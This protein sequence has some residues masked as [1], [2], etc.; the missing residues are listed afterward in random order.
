[1]PIIVEVLTC[2]RETTNIED[3]YAIAVN[4]TEE[5]FGHVPCKISFLCAAFILPDHV[6]NHAKNFVRIIRRIIVLVTEFQEKSK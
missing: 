5:V 1:M 3:R 4:K 6:Y 2:R